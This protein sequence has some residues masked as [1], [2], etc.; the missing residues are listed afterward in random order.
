MFHLFLFSFAISF[1]FLHIFAV[2]FHK[3]PKPKNSCIKYEKKNALNIDR[4]SLMCVCVCAYFWALWFRVEWYGTCMVIKNLLTRHG[5]GDAKKLGEKLLEMS[6]F[7]EW[8]LVFVQI[9][10]KES[11]IEKKTWEKQDRASCL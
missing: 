2:A 4:L 5:V 6:T 7:N 8:M 11:K 3:F 10:Q 1:I 9:K